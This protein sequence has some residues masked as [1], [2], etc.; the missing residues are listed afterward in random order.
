MDLGSGEQPE[1]AFEVVYTNRSTP[2]DAPPC[3]RQF[4]GAGTGLG[5]PTYEGLSQGCYWNYLRVYVPAG[6]SLRHSS[7]FP[8]PD[9]ALYRREGYADLTETLRVFTEHG[10]GVFSGLT[11]IDPGTSRALGFRYTLPAGVVERADGNLT[12]T[13]VIQ[14][15]PGAGQMSVTVEVTILWGHALDG[16]SPAPSEV[17]GGTVRFDL[18]LNSDVTLVVRTRAG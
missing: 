14:K 16:A 10:R 4:A 7:P 12:Y 8:L 17:D 18:D 9:G 15:Q 1:A 3:E 6:S 2:G 5:K 13:L 11:A